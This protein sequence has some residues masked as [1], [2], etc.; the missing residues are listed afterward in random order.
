MERARQGGRWLS[1]RE[2]D[3]SRAT[4]QVMAALEANLGSAAYEL[5][6]R[7]MQVRC[8]CGGN[9]GVG[10]KS[11][12][13]DDAPQ[14]QHVLDSTRFFLVLFEISFTAGILLQ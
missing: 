5:K 7:R 1:A 2:H 9:I 10:E 3:V 14:L 4:A 6:V 13:S 11:A 12:S 8:T